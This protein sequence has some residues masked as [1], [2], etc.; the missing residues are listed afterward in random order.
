MCLH[1]TKLAAYSLSSSQ[2]AL[3]LLVLPIYQHY[4]DMGFGTYKFK[5]QLYHI[6]AV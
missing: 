1:L 3:L 6:L 2:I 4:E 5:S